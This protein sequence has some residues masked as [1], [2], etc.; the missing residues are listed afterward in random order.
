MNRVVI[1]GSP[2]AGK[3]TLA[4]KLHAIL[5]IKV[6]HL[7]RVFWQTGWRKKPLDTRI[8]ILDHIVQN[9]EWIIEGT[10]LRSSEPRLEVADTIIFLG[11]PPWVCLWRIMKRHQEYEGC[12]RR[13]IPMGS[14]DKL[15]ILLILKV[16][17]YPFVDKRMFVQRLSNYT[18]NIEHKQV[19]WL[20][21]SKEVEDFLSQFVPC[22]NEKKKMSSVARN[23]QLTSAR[24]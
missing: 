19:I 9:H 22:A 8:E 14:K 24:R 12:A 4:R 7:D 15:T 1:I 20:K 23:R 5:N 11:I 21:S 17:F 13:D 3:T 18:F 10:Y 16:L 6:V 2:G